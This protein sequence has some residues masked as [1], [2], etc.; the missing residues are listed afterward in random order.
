MNRKD[1]GPL[2][3]VFTWDPKAGAVSD[4]TADLRAPYT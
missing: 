1:L 3:M 2:H 4:F